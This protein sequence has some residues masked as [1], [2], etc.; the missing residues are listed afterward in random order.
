MKLSV[1]VPVYNGEK[2][3]EECLHSLSLQELGKDDYEII[4]INDGSTD[5][6]EEIIDSFCKMHNYA[7]KMNKNS[8]G[9]I[10]GKKPWLNHRAGRLHSVC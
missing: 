10:I 5:K 9:G 7:H 8:G 2:Y 3:L 6:T 4:V 1:I